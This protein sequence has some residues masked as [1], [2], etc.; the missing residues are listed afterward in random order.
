MQAPSFS[1]LYCLAR[2]HNGHRPESLQLE[3]VLVGKCLVRRIVVRVL[4]LSVRAGTF[5]E[6]L[7][8]EEVRAPCLLM[9]RPEL[10]RLTRVL[11]VLPQDQVLLR[12]RPARV[13]E[14]GERPHY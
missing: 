3:K 7:A 6:D 8:V 4:F 13:A 2:S 14:I 5:D 1:M 12:E 9:K 11:R 10:L